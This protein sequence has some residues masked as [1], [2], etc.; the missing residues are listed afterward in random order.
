MKKY[1]NIKSSEAINVGKAETEEIFIAL[2]LHVQNVVFCLL[3]HM[4]TLLLWLL[5]LK[6]DFW[7]Q[8]PV[9]ADTSHSRTI[10]D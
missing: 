8:G 9:A 4:Y 2:D 1:S 10:F 3:L 5:W 6:V 7:I